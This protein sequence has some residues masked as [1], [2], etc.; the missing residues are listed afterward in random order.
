[1]QLADVLAVVTGGA[2]GLGMAVAR[3]LTSAGAKVAIWDQNGAAAKNLAA[4]IGALGLEVDVVSEAG[5]A[6]ALA[7]SVA[8]CDNLRVLINC[9]GIGPA[10]YVAG[11]KGVHSLELFRRVVDV[12]LVGSF[13]AARLFAGHVAKAAPC[14]RGERG[15]IVY[16]TSIA[17]FEGQMG[18]SA[19]AASKGGLV[20]LAL[21][22]ARDLARHGI[23]CVSVAPGIFETPMVQTLP[24]QMRRQ[25]INTTVF[26]SEIGQ[27]VDFAELVLEVCRNV[28]LN[29]CTIR[30]D[31]AMRLAPR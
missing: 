13:N 5:V 3:A 14:E 25:I 27:P 29:G 2:S 23:R 16:T 19:Y 6:D 30:I 22:M 9:A 12:N 11:P 7:S 15:V 31:G 20:S 18:Q 8:W 28:M 24:E 4:E 1:V 17:A 21:T 10:S 26:P